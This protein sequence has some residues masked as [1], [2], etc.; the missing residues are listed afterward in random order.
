MLGEQEGALRIASRV[1]LPDAA[2]VEDPVVSLFHSLH[3][4]VSYAQTGSAHAALTSYYSLHRS[5]RSRLPDGVHQTE[6]GFEIDA[7]QLS[8]RGG[9]MRIKYEDG[10]AVI[11]AKATEWGRGTLSR[12]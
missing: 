11:T 4:G 7:T 2:S 6:D 8:T 1:F 10:R 3:S 12:A 5:P 9:G